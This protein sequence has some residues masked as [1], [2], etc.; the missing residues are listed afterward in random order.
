MYSVA[1]VSALGTPLAPIR[2]VSK[3]KRPQS[4]ARPASCSVASGDQQ[5]LALGYHETSEGAPPVPLIPARSVLRSRSNSASASSTAVPLRPASPPP[6]VPNGPATLKKKKQIR[7]MRTTAARPVPG[8]PPVPPYPLVAPPRPPRPDDGDCLLSSSVPEKFK[9]ARDWLSQPVPPIPVGLL[10]SVPRTRPNRG[11]GY[12]TST[13][14]DSSGVVSINTPRQSHDSV[15]F[16]HVQLSSSA[17]TAAHVRSGPKKKSGSHSHAHEAPSMS[18][19]EESSDDDEPYTHERGTSRKFRKGGLSLI[20]RSSHK[21]S[22][23]KEATTNASHGTG[24][25][26]NL[27]TE[28]DSH[29]SLDEFRRRVTM[30]PT[31][32]PTNSLPGLSDGS[33]SSNPPSAGERTPTEDSF[34]KRFGRTFT[35]KATMPKPDHPD[36]ELIALMQSLKTPKRRESS[37]RIRPTY[38]S[39]GMESKSL[40][41]SSSSAA[42]DSSYIPGTIG[43]IVIH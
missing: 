13:G 42:K 37:A 12:S 43:G 14:S 27:A 11:H 28:G 15:D 21:H 39:A 23:S 1:P 31:H 41:L 8:A 2:S 29:G 10:A 9:P 18:V 3:H 26:K 20:S 4:Q 38:E 6:P 19:F 35:I 32:S 33:E 30:I 25:S 5:M 7:T 17:S 22:S 16:R 40:S 34:T 24:T 36:D